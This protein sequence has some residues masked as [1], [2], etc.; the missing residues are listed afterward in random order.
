MRADVV[1]QRLQAMAQTGLTFTTDPYDR[2][3]YEELRRLAAELLSN[4]CDPAPVE[5]AFAAQEG[6]ATPKVDVR[7]AVFREG[8]LLLVQERADGGWTLPGGWADVGLTP[9]ENVE[10][11]IW[12]EAGLKTRARRLLGVWDRD[13]HGAPPHTFHIYKMFFECE[14]EPG[15]PR[16][17]DETTDVGFFTLDNLPPLSIG[18]TLTKHIEWLFR[19]VQDP[20]AACYYD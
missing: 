14:A 18:R 8:R 5:A 2:N 1:A 13:R 11:E 16:A 15:E 17:S 19:V 7:G 12:E 3:R 6:Y 10:K 4:G 9:S 20:T